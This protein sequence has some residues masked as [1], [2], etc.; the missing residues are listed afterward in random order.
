MTCGVAIE[1]TNYNVAWGVGGGTRQLPNP[2]PPSTPVLTVVKIR[3]IYASSRN[4]TL[5]STVLMTGV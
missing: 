4:G 1:W 2:L 3:I 5:M